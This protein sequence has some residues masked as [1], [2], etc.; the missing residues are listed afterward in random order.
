MAGTLQTS[1]IGCSKF[2]RLFSPLRFD[3]Q[4]SKRFSW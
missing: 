2:S 3:L 1:I 4:K